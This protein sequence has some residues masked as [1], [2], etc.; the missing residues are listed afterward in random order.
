[1]KR[2]I[3]QTVYLVGSNG[4]V[5]KDKPW[6]DTARLVTSVRQKPNRR[7][8]MTSG[9]KSRS[10]DSVSVSQTDFPGSADI[11]KKVLGTS[12]LPFKKLCLV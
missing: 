11:G 2:S 6:P 5:Y 7:G 8:R 9:D 4:Y 1:M 12:C 10:T 3:I